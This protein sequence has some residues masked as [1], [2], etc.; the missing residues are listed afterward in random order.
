ML[1][2]VTIIDPSSTYIDSGVEIGCDSVVWPSSVIEG[3]TRVGEGCVI[4]PSSQLKNAEIGDGVTITHSV[5]ESSTIGDGTRIGPFAN[6]RPGCRIGKNV[7]LGDFVE[8][9]NSVISDSVSMAHLTYLGDA[10]VGEGSNIGAGSIT[11]NY[12]GFE[13]HKTEIGKKVFL[14]SNVTLVAPVRI[15][16]GS[17]V[18]AGTVVTEDVPQDALAISRCKQ[19]VKE[20][21]AERRRKQKRQ[22]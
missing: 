20:G 1:G 11:C 21:W 8:A 15:G 9:K 16:D 7:K 6:I 12:D 4:G 14:G 17:L 5:V 10:E 22:E 2:G 18:A 13:K 3:R 19:S